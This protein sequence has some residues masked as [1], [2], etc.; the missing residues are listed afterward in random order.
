MTSAAYPGKLHRAPAGMA[1]WLEL[2]RPLRRLVEWTTTALARTLQRQGLRRL[3]RMAI[4][5]LEA[6]DDRLLTDIGLFR[7]QIPE[8][9]DLLLSQERAGLHTQI[10]ASPLAN[11]RYQT[12]RMA[13]DRDFRTLGGGSNANCQLARELLSAAPAGL[14]QEIAP[15]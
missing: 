2:N 7:D 9:I 4:H 13:G 10:S 1:S 14:G 8:F 5:Q 12:E 6:L 3:R 15:R 11:C